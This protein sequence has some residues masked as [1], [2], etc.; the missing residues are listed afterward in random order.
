MSLSG[1]P[2]TAAP[3]P[4]VLPGERSA[5]GSLRGHRRSA[6]APPASTASRPSPVRRTPWSRA[7]TASRRRRGAA[8]RRPRPLCRRR[9]DPE[10]QPAGLRAGRRFARLRAGRPCAPTS[11]VRAPRWTAPTSR[12]AFLAALDAS[13]PP[14]T[15]PQRTA[16]DARPARRRRHERSGH[17]PAGSSSSTRPGAAAR[18]RGCR[19]ARMA[20]PCLQLVASSGWSGH[21]R[22]TTCAHR[23]ETP[24]SVLARTDRG[25]VS[26][27]TGLRAVPA[28]L[29]LGDRG[30]RRTS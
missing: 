23:P 3:C 24:R 13:G 17:S 6:S 20:P 11:T 1:D 2:Y 8:R 5:A 12:Q 15:T 26:G 9:R 28:V 19:P 21:S 30:R 10:R 29:R 16:A 14:T 22:C 25:D 4:D 27:W 7:S 18:A